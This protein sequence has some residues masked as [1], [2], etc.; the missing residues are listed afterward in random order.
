MDRLLILDQARARS[1]FKKENI[2]NISL[3][4]EI[5]LNSS[6]IELLSLK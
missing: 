1:C 6:D 5:Y 3:K 2:V 4:L